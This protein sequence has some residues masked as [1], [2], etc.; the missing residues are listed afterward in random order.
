MRLDGRVGRMGLSGLVLVAM[1]LPVMAQKTFSMTIQGEKQGKFKAES[2]RNG[3]IGLVSIV[4][5]RIAPERARGMKGHNPIVVTKE[6]DAASPQL[7]Q[8]L[9]THERLP[10]V[11]LNIQ[12]QGAGA[13]AGLRIAERV[14]LRNATIT[15]VRKVG[16]LEEITFAYEAI[17]VSWSDG[18]KSA[19]DDWTTQDK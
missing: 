9:N 18:S 8:A 5:E 14:E 3:E 7:F 10:V 4:H 16:R 2:T 17:T 11:A 13:G 19:S 12:S 1:A 6:V 15:S